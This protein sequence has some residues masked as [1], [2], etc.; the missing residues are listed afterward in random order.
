[1]EITQPDY[2]T[3]QTQSYKRHEQYSRTCNYSMLP[4]HL[5]HKLV[6]C[7]TIPAFSLTNGHNVALPWNPWNQHTHTHTHTHS[8]TYAHTHS[9]TYTLNHTHTQSFNLFAT[10]V[11]LSKRKQAGTATETW[12]YRADPLPPP[13][14]CRESFEMQTERDRTEP[15]QE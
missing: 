9:Y 1:M 4:E 10:Q 2:F 12:C 8:L 14:P 6:P 13:P 3:M 5:T 7:T 11:H 15:G